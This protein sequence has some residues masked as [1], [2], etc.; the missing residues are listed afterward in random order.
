MP[1][2]RDEPVVRIAGVP[3]PADREGAADAARELRRRVRPTVR[4]RTHRVRYNLVLAVQAGIAASLSWLV[5]HYLLQNPDPVFAPISAVGTLAASVGQR[6]RRTI[7]LIIG[8]AVGIGVGDLFI[9][10]F[11]VGWWQLGMIVT[12]AV[13]IAI[14]LGGGPSVVTQAAVTALLLVAL[15]PKA[16]DLEFPRVI[17]ALVGGFVALG[18]GLVLLPFNPL[19]VVDR[20]ARPALETLARELDVTSRAL[21]DGDPDRAQAALDRV[22]EVQ[23]HMAGL[24]EA[25]EA[26]RETATLAPVRWRRRG[27]LAQYVE[28]AEFIEH[29]VANAGTLIR[30]SVT[31]L[32]DGE[33]IPDPLPSAVAQLAEAVRQLVAELGAGLEPEAT[34]ERALRAVGEAGRAYADGV[35]FSGSVVVAQLRTTASDLLRA[36]GIDRIEANRQVRRAVESGRSGRPG[37]EPGAD[38]VLRSGDVSRP[39][40]MPA[41][42][43]AE[44]PRRVPTE[45][46]RD[47]RDRAE[48]RP[49][50]APSPEDE[51]RV[52]SAIAASVRASGPYREEAPVRTGARPAG[53]GRAGSRAARSD[54]DGGGSPVEGSLLDGSAVDGSRGG[55]SAGGREARDGTDAA[56]PNGRRQLR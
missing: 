9:V 13:L 18:V 3:V 46:D 21:A 47:D 23:Q 45:P 40:E 42:N 17:D 43:G 11:G 38:P 1:S 8:V 28:G 31:A 52:E 55:G 53:M 15:A 29:A 25:L 24:Q 41:E 7:E 44:K 49:A 27:A 32:E 19:R 4:E 5:A 51:R 26:G 36:S 35:G 16:S 39:G 2:Q 10:A 54:R 30:R 20:A 34:R 22:Q 12:L 6:L 14:F 48:H 37:P 56:E 33:P 50:A